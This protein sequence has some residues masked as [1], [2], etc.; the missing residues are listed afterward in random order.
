MKHAPNTPQTALALE[1]VMHDSGWNAGEYQ[2]LFIDNEQTADTI[3]HS[4]IR[5]VSL[6][7]ST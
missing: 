2:N 5:G 6:T 3:A 1:Q 4:H 7:G